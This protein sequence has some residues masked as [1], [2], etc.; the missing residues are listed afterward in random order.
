MKHLNNKSE[1][2]DTSSCKSDVDYKR[3]QYVGSFKTKQER[4]KWAKQHF[5][6][7]GLRNAVEAEKHKTEQGEQLDSVS[8]IDTVCDETGGSNVVV[9]KVSTSTVIEKVR[10]VEE[11]I[12]QLEAVQR[13]D[14]MELLNKNKG[15]SHHSL[16]LIA[17]D[18]NAS[19]KVEDDEMKLS[20]E[21][22]H[23]QHVGS[24][25]GS[26][27]SL[28]DIDKNTGNWKISGGNTSDSIIPTDGEDLYIDNS[29]SETDS[30]IL[31]HSRLRSEA[32][33]GR[34]LH[35]QKVLLTRNRRVSTTLLTTFNY[36][37]TY[38]LVDDR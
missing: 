4:Q 27:D 8:N 25:K 31:G 21:K 34:D 2:S 13:K 11:S 18:E 35:K 37:S 9:S 10:K 6:Q 19:N 32:V 36:Y 28:L 26:M 20:T 3:L 15:S 38:L 23:H 17:E 30:L 16:D 29:D 12:Q 7:C 22:S 14:I 24:D 5:E 1:D 33:D